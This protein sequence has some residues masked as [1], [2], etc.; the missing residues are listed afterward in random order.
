M[1]R[2]QA[3]VHQNLLNAEFGSGEYRNAVDNTRNVI[4][5]MKALTKELL[6]GFCWT[7]ACQL[8]FIGKQ[9]FMLYGTHT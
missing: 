1:K 7:Y 8:H 6:K 5:G 2:R 3:H 4:R 9:E